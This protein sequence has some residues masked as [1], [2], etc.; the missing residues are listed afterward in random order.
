MFICPRCSA[1]FNSYNSLAKHTNTKYKLSGENLYRE[2][3]GITE[4][5]TCKC[6][7]GTP[8]K[9]R[10]DRGYGKY[11]NG[12]NSRGKN[13][14]MFGKTHSREARDNI[15]SKRKSRFADGTLKVWCDGLTKETD[16]RLRIMGEN[17]SNNTERSI[18]ISNALSGV[19]KSDIHKQNSRIG[20]KKAWEDEE[21]REKQRINILNRFKNKKTNKPS[22]LEYKFI[23]ILDTLKIPYIFQYEVENRL[24]DFKLLNTNL[25]IE[26]DGDF[27]H[28]NPKIYKE[29][30]YETQ[31]LTIKND[32]KK[33]EIAYRSGYK[34]L[35]FWESDI[36]NNPQKVITELLAEINKTSP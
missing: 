24:Y 30:I 12:H 1:E 8:T 35:R 36:L 22:G 18:K 21:L 28:V 34:L 6:G 10:I 25:I 31:K 17:I 9:W 33:N 32:T 20:I 29:A 2:Y 19:P 11:A 7:C 4:I 26:V 14:V 13:N 16:E 3:H 15:S 5:V 27:H 23:K